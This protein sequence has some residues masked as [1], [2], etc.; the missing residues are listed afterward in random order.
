MTDSNSPSRRE[1]LLLI[2]GLFVLGYIGGASSAKFNLFPYPQLLDKPLT[3]LGAW[4]SRWT[5]IEKS[6][7]KTTLWHPAPSNKSGL[8]QKS[9]QKMAPGYTLYASAHKQAAFLLDENGKEVHRWEATFDR[10]FANPKHVDNPVPGRFVYWH[11]A[12]MLKGGDLIVSISASHSTPYGYGLVRLDKHSE[13]VWKFAAHVHHDFDVAPDGRVFALTHNLRDTSQSPYNKLP[14]LADSILDDFVVVLDKE[15]N[16]LKRFSVTEAV[17]KTPYRRM[18]EMYPYYIDDRREHD[19][20]PLHVNTVKVLPAEF[21]AHHP[22]ADK[23]DILVSFRNPDAVGIIDVETEKLVWASRGFWRRQ[24][25]PVPLPNGNILVFDNEGHGG[26]SGG[27]RLLEFDIKRSMPVWDYAGTPNNPFYTERTG[28]LQ[29]LSNGNILATES[30]KG[31]ILE[32]TRDGEVVWSYRNPATRTHKGQLFVAT[33]YS[34][35]KYP[36]DFFDPPGN[37]MSDN[38]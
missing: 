6:V 10:L 14:Y 4:S 18:L 13:I 26:P 17:L 29:V 15:G 33:V 28:S 16:K 19:W 37:S 20:D 9:P 7:L 38:D 2:L 34:G 8:I 35:R 27:S 22:F 32:V 3:A 1:T 23:G 12:Q 30:Q 11:R 5:N 25:S 21:A 36:P 24:H 31:R